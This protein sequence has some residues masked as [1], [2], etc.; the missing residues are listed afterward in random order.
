MPTWAQQILSSIGVAAAVAA[1]GYII[2]LEN[3][4]GALESRKV[5][6]GEKSLPQTKENEKFWETEVA[7]QSGAGVRRISVPV[8]FGEPF[9]RPPQVMVA[10]KRVDLG[11]Y[12]SNIHRIG[13]RAEGI[14]VKGFDLNI[15]TWF[16][17]LVFEVVV[18]WI[19]YTE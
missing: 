19:A 9:K 16:E 4:M 14:G 5:Q 13:V 3:R 15:E 10:L 6:T 1:I 12:K 8:E 2:R 17:S 7:K 11:D 18:S